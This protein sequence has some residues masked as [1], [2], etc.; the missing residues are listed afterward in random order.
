MSID[1]NTIGRA[2]EADAIDV[3]ASSTEMTALNPAL[4]KVWQA[5]SRSMRPWESVG[6]RRKVAPGTD[7]QDR[8]DQ[9]TTMTRTG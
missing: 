6:R 8:M 2:L 1:T 3:A 7:S 9:V 5:P 4:T